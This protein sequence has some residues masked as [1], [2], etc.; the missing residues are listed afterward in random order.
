MKTE[1]VTTIVRRRESD[2]ILKQRIANKNGHACAMCGAKADTAPLCFHYIV[3]ISS[4]G[5][6]S[7]ENVILLCPSCHLYT[8][9]QTQPREIEFVSFLAELLRVHPDFSDVRQEVILGGET[10]YRA[11]LLASRRQSAARQLLVI[12]CKA[13]AALTSADLSQVVAQLKAYSTACGDSRMAF[14]IPATLRETDRA[15]LGAAGIEVW[16]LAHV[17]QHFAAQI[18]R[19]SPGYY[20]RLLVARLART[21]PPREQL[22]M[23]ALAAC[24]PGKADCHV[25]QALVGEI[26]ECLFSP[27][28]EPPISGS[29]DMSEANRRDLIMPNHAESGSG[30]SCASDMR[31][32]TS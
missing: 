22:L 17:A 30:P 27:P 12:E 19:T 26:F 28:L 21:G 24:R 1:K 31:R 8:H 3:P 16:D 14:A 25:Y 5:I 7:E 18:R 4:G 11:D 20:K 32:T 9:R 13:R 15:T 10:R 6:D 23:N 29:S 2:P